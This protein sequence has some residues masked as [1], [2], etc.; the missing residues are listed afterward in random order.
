MDIA[1]NN[2]ASGLWAIRKVIQECMHTNVLIL[3]A[4]ERSDLLTSSCVNKE[5][6][7]YNRKMCKLIKCL[8]YAQMLK[9]IYK[10]SSSRLMKCM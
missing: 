3:N 6:V 7:H 2:T 10:G 5:A 9:V 8:D 1:R 4:C